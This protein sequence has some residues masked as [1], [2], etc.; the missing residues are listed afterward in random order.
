MSL[1]NHAPTNMVHLSSKMMTP[2]IILMVTLVTINTSLQN[3]VYAEEPQEVFEQAKLAA[4]MEFADTVT[5]AKEQYNQVRATSADSET[6]IKAKQD[7]NKAIEDAKKLR[8]QKID[9][10]KKAYAEAKKKN[11]TRN[12]HNRS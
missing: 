5:K 11:D 12:I 10:A 4:E 8:D 3:D 2:A 9:D 6:L 7:Y 1:A